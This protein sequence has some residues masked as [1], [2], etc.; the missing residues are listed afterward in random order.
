MLSAKGIDAYVEFTNRTDAMIATV[1][2]T[3]EEI[4]KLEK[5]LLEWDADKSMEN[6]Q[7][8]LEEFDPDI[9]PGAKL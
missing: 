1:V 5:M 2:M 3:E 4:V 8:I 9:P 7:K 6:E